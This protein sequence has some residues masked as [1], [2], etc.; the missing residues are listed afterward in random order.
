MNA[1]IANVPARVVPVPPEVDAED[2]LVIADGGAS[3]VHVAA[4]L[5]A[6]RDAA[7]VTKVASRDERGNGQCCDRYA[8]DIDG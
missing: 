3:V 8:S 1:S 7:A 5:R 4:P 6:W 2:E